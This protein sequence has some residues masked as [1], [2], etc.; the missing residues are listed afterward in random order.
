[1]ESATSRPEGLWRRSKQPINILAGTYGSP[2]HPILVT[3]PIGAWLASLVFDI[4]SRIGGPGP[5]LYIGSMW[6]IGIGIIGALAA[7]ASGFLDYLRI[8][9]KTHV[10]RLGLIH[11]GLNLVVVAV[12]IFNF[13]VRWAW[14]PGEVLL[15]SGQPADGGVYTWLIVLSAVSYAALGLSGHLGSLMSYRY[16]VRVVDEATQ[17]QGYGAAD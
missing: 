17:R 16:G 10:A 8:P 2:V 1:M 11:M 15:H 5:A 9:A 12:Y 3:V 6:L 4:G 14:Q 7:A 13:L